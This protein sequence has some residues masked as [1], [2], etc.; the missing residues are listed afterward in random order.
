MEAHKQPGR[1]STVSQS[2]GSLKTSVAGRP[3]DRR[4]S[5]GGGEDRTG[6]DRTETDTEE[7]LRGSPDSTG[8]Q[9]WLK[10]QQKVRSLHI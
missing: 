10:P 8:S 9:T 1:A 3:E 6:Q 7:L 2:G 5:S 4:F